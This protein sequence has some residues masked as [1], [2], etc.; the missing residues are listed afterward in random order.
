[1]LSKWMIFYMEIIWLLD[2]W[3]F[4]NREL[5]GVEYLF[6]ILN[7]ENWYLDSCVIWFGFVS[8]TL[9]NMD[10]WSTSLS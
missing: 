6:R 1:M 5:D 7:N 3:D 4:L 10:N 8:L 2:W 9:V